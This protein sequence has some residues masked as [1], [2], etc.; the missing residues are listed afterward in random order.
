MKKTNL[1]LIAISFGFASAAIARDVDGRY[2]AAN[3][4]LHSWFESLKSVSGAACC[5]D[6]DGVKIDDPAWRI[7]AKTGTYEVLLDDNWKPVPPQAVVTMP[8]KVG[9]AMLW[10]HRTDGLVDVIRCFMPGTTG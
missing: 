1:L 8:N 5:A 9:F 6:A 10:P 2:A 7:D 4:E 3:P